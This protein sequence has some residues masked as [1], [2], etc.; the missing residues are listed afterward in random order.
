MNRADR[1]YDV[2][3]Y[4]ADCPD[5]IGAAWA[6]WRA[7]GDAPTYIP[8]KHDDPVPYDELRGRRVIVLDFSFSRDVMLALQ[9]QCD[10][11]VVDH[12]SSAMESIG[13]LPNC[14]FD[15]TSSG[16]VLAWK[17]FFPFPEH[18]VPEVLTYIEDRDLD[19]WK[20]P[21]TREVLAL[22]DMRPL[23]IKSVE[24]VNAAI[25]DMRF[26]GLSV[27]DDAELKAVSRYKARAVEKHDACFDVSI[28]QS[29]PPL[30]TYICNVSCRD[31]ISD[32]CRSMLE[33]NAETGEV[34]I[35][36][37]WFYS[38]RHDTVYV[39]LR[40]AKDSTIDVAQV[41]MQFGGGGHKHAA[42]FVIRLCD[43][44]ETFVRCCTL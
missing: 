10:I 41:A 44:E 11:V 40:S 32:V 3:I 26:N 43:L 2:V 9:E 24:E 6:A 12:H 29:D 18:A 23:T 17:H 16:A 25:F 30:R 27:T 38:H 31:F 15:M 1:D 8:L 42:G 35:A 39:S 5:G 36:A 13:D 7:L 34:D 37:T 4:H 19:A 21:D 33:L 22:L 28:L 20:L 14:H